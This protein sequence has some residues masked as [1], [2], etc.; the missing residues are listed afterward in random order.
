MANLC[1]ARCRGGGGWCPRRRVFGD[2][3]DGVPRWP[4]EGGGEVEERG[5]KWWRR[6]EGEGGVRWWRRGEGEG[7]RSGVVGQ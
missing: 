7:G 3:A 5:L 2:P 4:P 6:G 1:K